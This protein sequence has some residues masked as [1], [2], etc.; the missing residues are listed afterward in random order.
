MK[1]KLIC[2]LGKLYYIKTKNGSV[3]Q[4]K[5]HKSLQL[6]SKDAQK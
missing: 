4:K 5:Q 1:K 2:I 3:D 6:D